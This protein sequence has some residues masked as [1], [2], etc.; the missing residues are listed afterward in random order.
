MK[1]SLYFAH[2][3]NARNDLKIIRLRT[4]YGAEG[5]GIFWMLIEILAENGAKI[6]FEDIPCIASLIGVK[7]ELLKEIITF[8]LSDK[9]ALFCQQNGHFFNK[10]I[11]AHEERRKSFIES[12]RQGARKRWGTAN[13]PRDG[14]ANTPAITPPNAIKK[15]RNKEINKEIGHEMTDD[16]KQKY[17]NPENIQNLKTIFKDLNALKRHLMLLNFPEAIIDQALGKHF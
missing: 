2:D 1:D 8:C 14:E 5:Y 6:E 16:E 9:I 3:L 12:G 17:I 4:K 10:R 15:E 7:E 13:I 11:I